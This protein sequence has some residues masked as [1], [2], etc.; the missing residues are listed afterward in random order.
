MRIPASWKRPSDFGPTPHM[1]SMAT[2]AS[3][4]ASPPGTSGPSSTPGDTVMPSGLRMSVASLAM[5]LLGPTPTLTVRPSSARV[6][7]RIAAPIS[8]PVPSSRLLPVQSTN[9]SST[10]SASTS[11]ENRPRI[12]MNRPLSSA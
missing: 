1:R 5:N 4:A 11:G 8:G 2:G 3:H 12:A 9:A 7:A 6:A 10:L